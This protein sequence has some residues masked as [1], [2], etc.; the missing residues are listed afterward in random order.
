MM[1]DH[2]MLVTHSHAHR[3]RRMQVSAIA[4]I[5]CVAIIALVTHGFPSSDVPTDLS[6]ASVTTVQLCTDIDF[7]GSCKFAGYGRCACKNTAALLLW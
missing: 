4:A 7:A 6:L 3:S 1:D 5:A 2:A